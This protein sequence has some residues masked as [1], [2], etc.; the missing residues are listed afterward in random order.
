M[1]KLYQ[2]VRF[3]TDDFDP[4]AHLVCGSSVLTTVCNTI[5]I[6]AKFCYIHVEL[7]ALFRINPNCDGLF[8]V[9]AL[10]PYAIIESL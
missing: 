6:T 4:L 3:V 7:S 9:K 1:L 10:I 2:T 8:Y 5:N